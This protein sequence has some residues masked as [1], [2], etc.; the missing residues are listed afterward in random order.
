MMSR[1]KT[2]TK[3]SQ[4]YSYDEILSFIMCRKSVVVFFC[5]VFFF[6]FFF[7]E[8]EKKKSNRFSMP[9]TVFS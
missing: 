1:N 4:Y 5:R 6:F 3:F 8:R 9:T 2:T 7:G